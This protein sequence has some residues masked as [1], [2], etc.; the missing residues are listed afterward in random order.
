MIE[1]KALQVEETYFKKAN[2]GTGRQV[3]NLL[4]VGAKE[5][6]GTAAFSKALS[7]NARPP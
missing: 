2:R 5:G 4:S 1:Q 6:E 3:L 7:R